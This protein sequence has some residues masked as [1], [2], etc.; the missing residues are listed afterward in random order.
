MADINGAREYE[1]Q[2]LIS[3]LTADGPVQYKA[4]TALAQLL[5]SYEQRIAD[6][7]AQ[8]ASK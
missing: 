8:L 5:A 4:E 1:L 7:E 3:D 6:L 2:A